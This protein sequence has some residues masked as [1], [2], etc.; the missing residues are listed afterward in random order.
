[1][2]E[3]DPTKSVTT[4]HFPEN[5]ALYSGRYFYTVAILF[6]IDRSVITYAICSKAAP[7]PVVHLFRQKEFRSID[8]PS[9]VQ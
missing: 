3:F 8:L 7:M 6:Y 9:N 4:L 1:M 2:I 5:V